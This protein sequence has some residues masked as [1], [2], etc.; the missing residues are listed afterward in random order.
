MCSFTPL[1]TA[2]QVPLS[3]SEG[4]SGGPARPG[5]QRAQPAE[6]ENMAILVTLAS[7]IST[8]SGISSGSRRTGDLGIKDKKL[9]RCLRG[10][11]A[12]LEGLGS[13]PI[14]YT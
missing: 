5:G 8:A 11:A 4:S 6:P 3:N 1:W 7:R 10:L 12:L 9:E 13:M 14:T 2:P